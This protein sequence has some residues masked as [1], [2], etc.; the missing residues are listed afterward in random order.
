MIKSHCDWNTT[1]K[2]MFYPSRGGQTCV[3]LWQCSGHKGWAPYPSETAACVPVKPLQSCLTLCDPM[4]C[5]LPGSSVHGILQARTLEWGATPFSKESSH[6][7]IEP[8]P[9]S[10]AGR[11]FT[12]STAC[13]KPNVRKHLTGGFLCA[14]LDLSGI[15]CSLLIPE[16]SGIKRR[17]KPLPGVEE[18]RHFLR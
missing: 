15:L 1:L 13:G 17:G 18:S 2:L 6:P 14:V 4:D 9:P 7:G 12:T 5:S 16:Y 3:R 8:A 10:L 11:F